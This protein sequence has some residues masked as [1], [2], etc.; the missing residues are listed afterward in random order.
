[1]SEVDQIERQI[2]GLSPEDLAQF[3][4]W[5]LEYDEGAWGRQIEGDSKPGKLD[6]MIADALAEQKAPRS[7]D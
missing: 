6:R 3:R 5:F 7:L 4:A 1:M 2:E